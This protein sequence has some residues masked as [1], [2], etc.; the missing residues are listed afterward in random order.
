MGIPFGPCSKLWKTLEK[1][2]DDYS[3]QSQCRDP[4]S[5]VKNYEPIPREEFE[6]AVFVEAMFAQS[7]EAYAEVDAAAIDGAPDRTTACFQTSEQAHTVCENA[8]GVVTY[9]AFDGYKLTPPKM[10]ANRSRVLVSYSAE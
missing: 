7:Q 3:M 6:A 4:E 9:Q 2:G 10:D 5:E 1:A 8:D